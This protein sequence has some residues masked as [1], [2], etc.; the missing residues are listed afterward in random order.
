MS[1]DEILAF[2]E[3]AA[4]KS[5]TGISFDWVPSVGGEPSGFRFMCRHHIGEPC[6]TILEAIQ[7][8]ARASKESSL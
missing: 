5:S 2:L 7:R 3:E 4:R 1:G 6:R 8:E